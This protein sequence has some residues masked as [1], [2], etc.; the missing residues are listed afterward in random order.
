M[1]SSFGC[2]RLIVSAV[3][4]GLASAESP[5]V[6]DDDPVLPEID[7]RTFVPVP[8][9]GEKRIVLARKAVSVTNHTPS[10]H[11]IRRKTFSGLSRTSATSKWVNAMLRVSS[12]SSP[13][14]SPASTRCP[15]D[16]NE[17][18]GSDNVTYKNPCKMK[19]TACKLRTRLV[20]QNWGRCKRD[21]LVFPHVYVR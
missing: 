8:N 18:C 1:R 3:V 16:Y 2:L 15:T 13:T 7:S 19:Q 21:K 20:F 4:L 6:P 10:A 14:M 9:G 17:V 5:A 12:Q 11:S